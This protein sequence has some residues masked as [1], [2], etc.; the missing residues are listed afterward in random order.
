[1]LTGQREAVIAKL[2]K[3]E[4][5]NDHLEIQGERNKSGQRILVPLSPIAL[6]QIEELGQKNGEFIVSNT[7]VAKPISGFSKLKR[8]VDEL[9]VVG[10]WR[11]HDIRR[12][13]AT[14]LEDN[15]VDRFYVERV[16][17]HKDRSVT[18][19][20]A[21]YNHLDVRRTILDR[22]ALVLT[23]PEGFDADNVISF[24]GPVT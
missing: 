12:G 8:K 11:F 21:R 13:I 19:I 9:S 15:G 5:K 1:M 24:T 10:D 22:W 18:G 2:S 17:T 14:H 16:L 23:A 6:Q 7:G 3:P 4:L 20:Y